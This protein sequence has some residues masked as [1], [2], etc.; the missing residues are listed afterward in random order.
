MIYF[1]RVFYDK[2]YINEILFTWKDSFKKFQ[3][4]ESPSG[5]SYLKVETCSEIKAEFYNQ[6]AQF[7]DEY[8]F[9]IFIHIKSS[10]YH[11][12][13]IPTQNSNRHLL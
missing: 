4:V 8:L 12:N 6:S 2:L 3:N 5:G 7:I 13:L 10:R 11:L 9:N 1:N